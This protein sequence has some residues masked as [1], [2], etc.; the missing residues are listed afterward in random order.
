MFLASTLALVFVTCSRHSFKAT[1]GSTQ[2]CAT[3]E[4]SSCWH[5]ES[6]D[7]ARSAPQAEREA[8]GKAAAAAEEE[9]ARLKRR[10]QEA[11]EEV[12][13]AMRRH[14]A[15]QQRIQVPEQKLS[16][17]IA[18]SMLKDAEMQLTGACCL[19]LLWTQDS[20]GQVAGNGTGGLLVLLSHQDPIVVS[21]DMPKLTACRKGCFDG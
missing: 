3:S 16:T 13:E 6:V 18:R 21:A 5:L 10:L 1:A 15:D 20:A 14:L 19:C 2:M 9:V 4:V 12:E 11:A 8:A 17:R 7:T